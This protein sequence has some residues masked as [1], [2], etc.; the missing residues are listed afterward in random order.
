[1]T[2]D[3]LSV[4]LSEQKKKLYSL[5]LTHKIAPIKNPLEIGFTRKD[6]ARMLTEIRMREIKKQ[7]ETKKKG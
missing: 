2:D 1:M 5:K 3:E 4:R 6:I 7:A